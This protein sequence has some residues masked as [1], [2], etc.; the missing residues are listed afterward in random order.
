M[1]VMITDGSETYPSTLLVVDRVE[2]EPDPNQEHEGETAEKGQEN[3]F[4]DSDRLSLNEPAG[5]SKREDEQRGPSNDQ[6]YE[7]ITE[8]SHTADHTADRDKEQA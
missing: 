8:L 1:Q 4:R 5:P 2:L 3:R 7:A 6:Q